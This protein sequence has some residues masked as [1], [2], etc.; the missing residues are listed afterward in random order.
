MINLQRLA[1]KR[2][3]NL[4]PCNILLYLN[5]ILLSWSV[6]ECIIVMLS[7]L[8]FTSELEYKM[9]ITQGALICLVFILAGCGGDKVI[10]TKEFLYQPELL[11]KTRQFCME[12]PGQRR[13]LQ[14]CVNSNQ[15]MSWKIEVLGKCYKGNEADK[16]CIDKFLA[17]VGK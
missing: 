6:K 11:K 10:E 2:V 12:N 13:D 8:L 17:K 3:A 1:A 4:W 15:A 16:A 14:N 9:K 5:V 7:I